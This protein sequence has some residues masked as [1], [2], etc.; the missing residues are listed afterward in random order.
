MKF[1]RLH[2]YNV[3]DIVSKQRKFSADLRSRNQ[4]VATYT[5]STELGHPFLYANLIDIVDCEIIT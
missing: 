1:M 2:I 4:T 3:I 5:F